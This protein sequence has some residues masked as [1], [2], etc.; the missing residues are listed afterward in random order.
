MGQQSRGFDQDQPFTTGALDSLPGVAAGSSL[1]LFG[2]STSA[3]VP[4]LTPTP[5]VELLSLTSLAN[6]DILQAIVTDLQGD[7]IWFLPLYRHS[8]QI[9]VEWPFHT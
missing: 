7:I 9:H 1:Q 3:P 5:G 4:G 6:Q 8:D 2:I